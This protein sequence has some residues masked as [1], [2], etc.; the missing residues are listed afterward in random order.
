MQLMAVEFARNVLGVKN[1]FSGEFVQNPMSASQK[2]R[3]VINFMSGQYDKEKGG[4]MR[5]GS[6]PC[7]LKAGSLAL[8]AYKKPLIQERHRHRLEFQNPFVSRFEKAGMLVSGSCPDPRL[9]EILELKGHPW[10]L[11]CQ[12]H[13][14]FKSRPEKPHPLFRAFIGASIPTRP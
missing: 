3:L 4:T 10:F 6:Y 13:P 8:K 12:F 7:R 5:L 9:V 11:G 2:K 1:A 14:E